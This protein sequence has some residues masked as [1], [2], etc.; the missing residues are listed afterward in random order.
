[1]MCQKSANNGVK[2]WGIKAFIYSSSDTKTQEQITHRH[3][4]YKT[5][6]SNHTILQTEDNY[7]QPRLPHLP[8][9]HSCRVD[10]RPY[11]EMHNFVWQTGGGTK[12]IYLSIYRSNE[13]RDGDS[14]S[15]YHHSVSCVRKHRLHVLV[16][17]LLRR[18]LCR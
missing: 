1:M 10:Q 9:P 11:Q 17:L 16:G 6:N 8:H 5:P 12:V 13:Y 2:I 7:G 3:H 18:H 14:Y 15:Y 4:Y